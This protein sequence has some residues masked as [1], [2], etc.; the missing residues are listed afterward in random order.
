MN[1]M[2]ERV[3]KE[4][5]A[6]VLGVAIV[7]RDPVRRE[8]DGPALIRDPTAAM[9]SSPHGFLLLLVRFVGVFDNLGCFRSVVRLRAHTRHLGQSTYNPSAPSYDDDSTKNSHRMSPQEIES[10]SATTKGTKS[11]KD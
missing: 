7:T 10:Q 1:D 5:P 6:N 11:T 8:H 9:V 2:S 3:T 4:K